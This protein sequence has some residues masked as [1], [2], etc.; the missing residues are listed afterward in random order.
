MYKRLQ[1]FKRD[2]FDDQL[3]NHTLGGIY[4]GYSSIDITGDYRAIFKMFGKEAHFYRLGTHPEL[5]GKDKI[6]T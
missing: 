3:R 4:R 1:L 6:S 2:P 5:Y